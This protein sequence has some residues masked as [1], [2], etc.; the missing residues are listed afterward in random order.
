M[1]NKISREEVEMI[2]NALNIVLKNYCRTRQDEERYEILIS[3]I[4]N[5]YDYNDWPSF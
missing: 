1:L 4:K 3:H 5:D 2:I